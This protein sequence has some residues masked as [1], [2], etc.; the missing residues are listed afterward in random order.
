MNIN[1]EINAHADVTGDLYNNT[2]RKNWGFKAQWNE[3][4]C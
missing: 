1:K 2:N 3:N 4:V